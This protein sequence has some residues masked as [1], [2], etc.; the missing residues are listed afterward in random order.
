MYT[1]SIYFIC[2]KLSMYESFNAPSA[3]AAAAIS[4]KKVLQSVAWWLR[5]FCYV[6]WTKNET[7]T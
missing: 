4:D 2:W 1:S 7:N 6:E 3:I 5:P